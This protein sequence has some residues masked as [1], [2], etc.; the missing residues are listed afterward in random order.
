M[1]ASFL[2][3][4]GLFSSNPGFRSPGPWLSGAESPFIGLFFSQTDLKK[5]MRCLPNSAFHIFL[6]EESNIIYQND[7]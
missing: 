2:R 4:S 7:S 3:N 5:E 1:L 6:K